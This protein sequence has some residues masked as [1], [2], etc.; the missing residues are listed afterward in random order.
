MRVLR[1]RAVAG[2]LLLAALALVLAGLLLGITNPTV[3]ERRH[4][5]GSASE[6]PYTCLAPY[7]TVLNDADNVPGG[8]PA[9][10]DATIAARCRAAGQ[11]RY[12]QGATLVGLGVLA[13]VGAAA[14]VVARRRVSA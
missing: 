12:R 8:E 9:L 5:A 2:S 11:E 3:D 1:S 7:D 4:W 14:G 6:P 10:N 13:G